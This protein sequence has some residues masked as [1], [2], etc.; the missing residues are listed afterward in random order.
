MARKQV[1]L[2]MVSILLISTL[3]SCGSTYTASHKINFY[4]DITL[5]GS[6][7]GNSGDKISDE[8]KTTIDGYATKANYTFGGWY[9]KPDFNSGYSSC[10]HYPFV[11]TNLYAKFLKNVT[12]TLKNGSETVKTYTGVEGNNITEV[13]SDGKTVAVT[14]P[15]VSKENYTFEGWYYTNSASEEVKFDPASSLYPKEDLTLYA[16]FTAWPTL[17]FVTNMAGFDMADMIVEPNKAIE[18]SDTVKSDLAT[19]IAT[20]EAGGAKKF[21]KWYTSYNSET[22]TYS[23]PFD[24]TSGISVDTTLYAKF[25]TLRTINFVTNISGYTIPSVSGFLGDPLS[26]PVAK[27]VEGKHLMGWYE[28]SDFSTGLYS[29]TSFPDKDLTLYAKFEVNPIITIKDTVDSTEDTVNKYAAGAVIDLNTYINVHDNM[30]FVAFSTSDQISETDKYIS[31]YRNYKIPDTDTNLFILYKS[32]YTFS[33]KTADPY[34][35]VITTLSDTFYGNEQSGFD[36]ASTEDGSI[37]NIALASLPS[38]Y[39]GAKVAFFTDNLT[40]MKPLA[41]PLG[42]SASGSTIFA[43]V[44]KKVTLSVAIDIAGN[45]TT[46]DIDGY[47]NQEY[48]SKPL[49]KDSDTGKYF[50]YGKNTQVSYTEYNFNYAYDTVNTNEYNLT[51]YAPKESHTLKLKFIKIEQ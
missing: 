32:D 7:E 28:S 13:G 2:P 5:L 36:L 50:F 41:S 40:T 49:V 34:G 4:D 3:A 31:D 18:L 20:E 10:T 44:A 26:A 16:K 15:T 8:N 37:S 33:V 21:D 12:I 39:D 38:G 43:I 29:F 35:N 17:K 22:N 27:E 48:A 14:F 11:D 25:L 30:N 24:F 23:Y 6:V 9:T 42:I 45:E 46:F 1:L 47:Q 51:S 19:H